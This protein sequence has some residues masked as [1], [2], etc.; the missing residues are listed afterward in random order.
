MKESLRYLHNA[1][2]ILNKS[3]IEDNIYTDVKDVKTAC[4]LAYLAVLKAID[5]YLLN[6]GLTK[7][8]LPRKVEEY[9]KAIQR[10]IS[11]HDGRLLREFD[12]LYDEL[13]IAGYYRGDLRSVEVVKAIFKAAEAFIK[14]IG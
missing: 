2:E 9:M 8:E 5:E 7:K 4:G 13:H 10:Y 1:K 14:R 3:P 11:V 12:A 6:K